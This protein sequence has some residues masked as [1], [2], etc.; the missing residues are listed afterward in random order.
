MR[1]QMTGWDEYEIQ[2]ACRLEEEATPLALH[3]ACRFIIHTANSWQPTIHPTSSFSMFV[4]V[5]C[6]LVP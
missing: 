6:M 2:L 1:E 5:S 3:V 4:I